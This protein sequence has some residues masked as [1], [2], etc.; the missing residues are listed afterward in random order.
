[1]ND[2]IKFDEFSEI[3]EITLSKETTNEL[4]TKGYAMVNDDMV[5]GQYF[6]IKHDDGVYLTKAV[7]FHIIKETY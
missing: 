3:E 1:M 6:V 7:G 2:Y 4:N 5:S